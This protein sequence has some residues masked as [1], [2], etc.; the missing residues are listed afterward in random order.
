MKN[1][2]TLLC[3]GLMCTTVN[4]QMDKFTYDNGPKN[5][6]GID[7]IYSI[8]LSSVPAV[9]DGQWYNW[10]LSAV[11]IGH[12]LYTVTFAPEST[13]PG[14]THSN[15]AYVDISTGVRYDSKL[16]L[17]IDTTGI[18]TIGERLTRQ[19]FSLNTGNVQDSIVVLAQDVS[20]SAPLV[21]M[22]YPCTMGTKW[23]STAQSITNISLTYTPPAPAPPFT[24]VPGERRSITTSTNE[25]VGWGD[26]KIKRLDG[27]P[28][29]Q[30]HVMLVKNTISTKDSFF[31]NGAPAPAALLAQV[32]IS[33]GET[34]VVYQKSFYREYEMMPMC[35]ITY[36]NANF[37]DNEKKEVNMHVQRLPY[38][39]GIEDVEVMVTEIFPNPNNGTFTVKVP[40]AEN[41]NWTYN[42][43]D[44]IGKRVHTGTLSLGNG[45]NQAVVALTGEV[46]AGTYVVTVEHDG[47]AVSGRKVV[48]Q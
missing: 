13:F 36:E 38:P 48:I 35:N 15:L 8:N 34:R 31:L 2:F 44:V 11:V 46:P 18:K 5:P 17:S 12:Y 6:S 1:L 43:T 29:G 9:P 30:R 3:A 7:S 41:G 32:G 37:S 45:N 19:A 33:Q 40:D 39:D 26:M 24:N 25:V 4:A 21:R 20:Y 10:D 42:V 22:P 47:T 14:A 27:K 28:S 23:N 16:M